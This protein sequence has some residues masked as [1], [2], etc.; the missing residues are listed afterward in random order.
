MIGDL[1]RL[2]LDKP[3]WKPLAEQKAETIEAPDH[4]QPIIV[5]PFIQGLLNNA[6]SLPPPLNF[7]IVE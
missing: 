7:P 6:P 4:V 3:C 2:A 1:C 5:W